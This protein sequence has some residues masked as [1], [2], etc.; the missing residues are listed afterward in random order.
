MTMYFA[1]M[2]I[3]SYCLWRFTAPP[4]TVF[5]LYYHYV[6]LRGCVMV[7]VASILLSCLNR[8][9]L[10]VFWS[11][12]T[13]MIED[14]SYANIV[15]SGKCCFIFLFMNKALNFAIP[16]FLILGIATPVLLSFWLFRFCTSLD[17]QAHKGFYFIEVLPQSMDIKYIQ[18]KH[19]HISPQSLTMRDQHV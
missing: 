2:N 18:L 10:W 14:H 13:A 3:K 11:R 1:C 9:S 15:S 5:K 12:V 7:I 16:E 8:H 19:H 4:Q 17:F 6:L